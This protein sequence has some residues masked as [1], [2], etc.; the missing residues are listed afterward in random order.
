[1]TVGRRR[2]IALGTAALAAPALLR[3]AHAQQPPVVVLKLHHFLSPVAYAHTRFLTPWAKSVEKDSNGRI[4]IDLF[5]SM[6][7]GGTASQLY[8]QA[9]NGTADIVWTLPSMTPGRFPRIEVFELPFVAN[10]RA[11]ANTRAVQQLYE[12]RL[13]DEFR[14]VQP[15]CL[16]A[17]DRGVL[18]TNKP[19]NRLED[20]KG[21]K[22]RAPT[23][24]ANEALKALGANGISLPVPQIPDALAAKVID[25]ALVPWEVVPAIKLQERVKFHTEIAGSP[26]LYT[27]TFILAMNKA[28]YDS[29]PPDLKKVIDRHSGQN[30]AQMA[31][32]MWDDLAPMV[33]DTARKQGNIIKELDRPEID[34]WVKAT[35]PVIDAWVKESRQRKFDGGALLAE[36][37][38]LLVKFGS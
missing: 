17:H 23:R 13:R 15:I 4:R 2:F 31:G 19:I 26:T 7:L 20:L 22:L 11:L 36:A 37:K 24:L 21:L 30:A 8:D 16:W 10:Q 38:A 32:R 9:V 34:R 1:M 29:L 5:P 25:G 33:E 18:H 14:E 27:A 6:Q 3:Q 28:R 35:Q 12:T